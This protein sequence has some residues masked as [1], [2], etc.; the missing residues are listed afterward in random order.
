MILH[1]SMRG[2]LFPAE[3]SQD[4]QNQQAYSIKNTAMFNQ[5]DERSNEN[6]H[7]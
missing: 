6:T 3:D 5:Y 7:T 1:S 4:N 2:A